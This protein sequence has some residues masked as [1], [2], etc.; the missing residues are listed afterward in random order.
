M[1]RLAVLFA[2][3]SIS[4]P[5]GAESLRVLALRSESFFYEKDGRPAGIEYELL[6]YF[7]KSRDAEL[8]IEWV[9]S[10]PELLARIEQGDADVAA[11][12]ITITSEREQRMDF[13]APYFPVQIVLVERA[14]ERTESLADLAG[15]IVGAFQKTTAED[16][17]KAVP[18][19]EVVQGGSLEEMMRA[20]AQG[21]LRAAAA[22][23]S[24]VIPALEEFPS[25]QLGLVFGEEQSFGFALPEGSPLKEPLSEHILQIRKAGIYF[26]I[27]TE[28]LGPQASEIVRVAKSP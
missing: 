7:A 8:A 24:A 4:V 5:A 3:L 1:K 27:V 18:G 13:S 9:G 17:L 16:A 12:T 25:L 26:R 15:S 19:I 21:K 23:S 20:V 28:H 10:F 2:C 14:G 22:D 11:G 6:H